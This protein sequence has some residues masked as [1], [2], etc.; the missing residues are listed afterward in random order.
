MSDFILL[1]FLPMTY[2]L[3]SVCLSYINADSHYSYLCGLLPKEY[4]Q[5]LNSW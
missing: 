5:Q 1:C 3:L 4:V 2:F